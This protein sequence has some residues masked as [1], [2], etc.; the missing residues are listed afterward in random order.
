MVTL[1]LIASDLMAG[2]HDPFLDEARLKRHF[3]A[4]SLASGVATFAN[5]VFI[6]PQVFALALYFLLTL[7]RDPERSKR[8]LVWR[9]AWL[10]TPFLAILAFWCGDA[11]MNFPYASLDW[12]EAG[13]SVFSTF[14]SMATLTFQEP[15]REL[16]PPHVFRIAAV[17]SAFSSYIYLAIAII[18]A[19]SVRPWT[20]R[21]GH[22]TFLV[23][24]AALFGGL[25]V[26]YIYAYAVIQLPFPFTRTALPLVAPIALSFSLLCLGGWH[27]T[28]SPL[29]RVIGIVG[30]WM[31]AFTFIA[32]L[33]FDYVSEWKFNADIGQAIKI[34]GEYARSNKVREVATDS[35]S[36][37]AGDFYREYYGYDF[38]LQSHETMR[39]GFVIYLISPGVQASQEF[40]QARKHNLK[41]LFE[42]PI[43]H[44]IVAV[45]LRR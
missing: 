34:A 43:S 36:I 30:A 15:N 1:F 12:N 33:H 17:L 25:V 45:T 5:F 38:D 32:A 14:H 18:C 27:L 3:L 26:F 44:L 21:R 39:D 31:L 8:K 7:Y 35:Q 19:L 41:V 9:A 11:M 37:A 13:A 29:P 4:A 16:L 24:A 2:A 40:F 42:S 28:Q 22:F 23:F 10:A 20:V 6:V